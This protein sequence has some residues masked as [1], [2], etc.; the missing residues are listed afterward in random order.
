M[1]ALAAAEVQAPQI[2]C[3]LNMLVSIPALARKAFSH[4]AIVEEETG[5]YGLIMK[6]WEWSLPSLRFLVFSSYAL[7][8]ITGH[9][10]G[11]ATKDG[12]K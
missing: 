12:K 5:L 6:S 4:L 7:S 9:S 10:L 2:E 1:P 8:A 11:L 3:A